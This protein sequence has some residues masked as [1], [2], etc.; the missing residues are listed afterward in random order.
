MEGFAVKKSTSYANQ[1]YSYALHVERLTH[2]TTDIQQQTGKF[3][4][5]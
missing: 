5:Y 3:A 2:F 1:T 4:H